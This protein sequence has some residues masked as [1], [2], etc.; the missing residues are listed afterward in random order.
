[1]PCTY[2]GSPLNGPDAATLPRRTRPGSP[3]ADAPTENGWL[4]DQLGGGFQLLAI[5]CEAPDR[6]EVD[7]I[8]VTALHVPLPSV[9]LRDRYLGGEASAVYLMRPDQHVAARWLHHEA[10]TVRAA[11]N[12]AVGRLQP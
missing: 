1:V 8:T 7:G 9:E 12:R 6:C 11:V 10:A 3:A 5:N 4:L 2:D